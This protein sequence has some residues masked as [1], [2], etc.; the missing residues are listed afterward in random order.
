[1]KF[2]L[3]LGSILLSGAIIMAALINSGRMPI[4]D[5]NLIAT[6]NGHVNLGEVYSEKRLVDVTFTID[7]FD[8]EPLIIKDIS[9]NDY[10]DAINE[11][12]KSLVGLAN[13]GRDDKEKLTVSTIS[14]KGASHLTLRS[15]V[16]YVSEH[17]PLFDLTLTEKTI[18]FD[19]NA[20]IQNTIISNV[21]DFVKSQYA[22]YH[23][24]MFLKDPE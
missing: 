5:T 17:M 9:A 6:T 14:A 12:L 24:A 1:M 22:A 11:K 21:D 13:I 2:S 4:F 8:V 10:Q 15:H 23:N 3:I 20:G 19:K 18:D 7:G 16:D